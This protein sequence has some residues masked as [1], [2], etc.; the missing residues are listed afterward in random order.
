[1]SLSF[2]AT[3]STTAASTTEYWGTVRV[4][5]K[6]SATSLRL[7][8]IVLLDR[9]AR[10]V[11]EIDPGWANSSL[12]SQYAP[13]CVKAQQ[14]AARTYAL[15]QG[16][17]E[18]YDN[19]SDQVYA[20]YTYEASHPGVA[21]AADATAGMVI[22]YNGDPITA[23][24][25]SHSGGYL[26]YSSSGLPYLV[27]KP[28]P[29]SLAAPVPPWS[30]APG[31]PWTYTFSAATL[32]S[33]LGV[34]VGTITAVEVTARDT[35]DPGSHART[36]TITGT[37]R[38]TTMSA[39]TF[40]SKLGLKSTLIVDITGGETFPGATR[41]DDTD[42]HLAYAGTWDPFAKTAAWNGSYARAAGAD[43][44]V[45]IYF[46]G[47][48]LDW[49]AMQGTTTGIADVYLDGEFDAT[50]DLSAS[51]A[52]Y[53]VDVWS[54]GDL[55]DAP[56][57]VRIERNAGSPA[58]T[59][60]TIDAVDLA[61][62]LTDPPPPPAP[63]TITGLAPG[64]GSSAGG[65]S[66]TITGTSLI[67]ASAVTFGGQSAA[68]FHVD[69]STQ[70]TAVTPA[71]AV[72]SAD[73]RVTTTAG[74]SENTPADDF[75]YTAAPSVTRYDQTNGNI[76]KTG[77]WANY[78][79]P[80]SYL[81]SYGR[82]NT[83]GA[84]ATIWFTGTQLDYIAFK[85][86]TTG[87]A[88][89]W[90]DGVKVTG[91]SPINLHASPAAYQQLVWTTGPLANGLHSVKIVRSASSASGKYLTLDAVDIYGTISAPPA[92]YEQAD[93]RIVKTGSWT[94]F[95]KVAASGGSY[96]RSLTSSP[97]QASATIYFTGSRLDWIAMKGTTAGVADV[98][99]DG[100]KVATIDLNA[101]TATYDLPVWSTGTLSEGDHTV[102][103][104]RNLDSG[105][106]G[107]LTLDAV[108]I[109]GAMRTA[110]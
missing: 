79:S 34:S 101:A 35:S 77:T 49:I 39:S 40:K 37:S 107:Y 61:G 93:T 6:T 50:V 41:S 102:R 94:T 103:I 81:G 105:T 3:S 89:I 30:I 13:E 52:T 68:S 66:V 23:N 85:G 73:V 27:A 32:A 16:T 76:V 62:T 72:G 45:N 65:T 56:H 96:S 91:S 33:K 92:R 104:V 17:S 88:E 58:G 10:G 36:L 43:A 21:A 18:L 95:T 71:H 87:Y 7:Y 47:T 22:T 99:L 28:D 19:S 26:S 78:G 67:G 86:T 8:N 20:G 31:Y 46:T 64:N 29:W 53:Q 70:M 15:D 4:E 97:A 51:V 80:P 12:S 1:V 74:T 106:G 60:V 110:P 84:S 57:V 59:F 48:R 54:T 82:S 9:Y 2:W 38:S 98:Y 75:T 55:A 5:P 14:T 42:A 11:A 24:Y 44:A 108:D 100:D 83:T 90:V 69:S 25:S 63:P 109:W